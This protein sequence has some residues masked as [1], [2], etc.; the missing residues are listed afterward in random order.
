MLKF[1][2]RNLL[3][4]PA[5]SLLSLLGLTVAIAGMVGLFSVAEGLD[6]MV[7]R[8]FGRISG[9]VAMQPG[10]PIPLFST[11]PADWGDEI[12]AVP[13][14]RAVNAEVWQRVNVIDGKMVFSPPRFLFGTDIPSRLRLEHGIYRD[15]IE[16]GRFLTLEDRGM[17]NTVISRQIAEEFHKGVGQTMRVNGRDLNIVGIY[18]CGSLLLGVGIILDIDQ[19]RQMTRFDSNSVSGFYIE[20]TG[21]VDDAELVRRIQAVFHGRDIHRWQPSALNGTAAIGAENPILKFFR[22]L[23]EKL[24]SMTPPTGRHKTANDQSPSQSTP[25]DQPSPGKKAA[26]ATADGTRPPNSPEVDDRV[27]IE[28]RSSIDWAERFDKFTSDLDVFLTIITAIG[29][30]IAVL[31]IVN[32]ML[33]SVTERIIE[34]GILKANG[35]SRTDVMRLITYESAVLGIGGGLCGALL[36]WAAAQGINAHWPTRVQLYASPGLLVFSVVFATLLGILGGLYPAI[37]AMRMMPMD[38]IRRG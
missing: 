30:V 9:L 7:T 4:R 10:A 21:E 17:P 3:S 6:A 19:V 14:V 5:R 29:V 32:T 26:R 35:W 1:A 13:G 11:L 18:H 16:K 22:V 23:G 27:P 12:A 37:W 8:T 15:Q 38:A 33:M 31:G 34:F 24:D 28:V 25:I 2:L 20:Q 36:G